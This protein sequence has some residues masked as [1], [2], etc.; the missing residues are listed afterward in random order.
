[1]AFFD[2]VK[3]YLKFSSSFHVDEIL[4]YASIQ[5]PSELVARVDRTH[6]GYLKRSR[7]NKASVAAPGTGAISFLFK[8]NNDCLL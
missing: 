6:F 1:M 2:A 3:K 5:A 7:C 4:S 8:F